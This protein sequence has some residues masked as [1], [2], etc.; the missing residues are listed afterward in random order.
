MLLYFYSEKS[1]KN[2]KKFNIKFFFPGHP[3][4]FHQNQVH[5]V[6]IYRSHHVDRKKKKVSLHFMLKLSFSIKINPSG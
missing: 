4:I 1:K 2:K 6:N 3:S 5:K